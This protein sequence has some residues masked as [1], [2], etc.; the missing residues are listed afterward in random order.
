MVPLAYVKGWMSPRHQSEHHVFRYKHP[1][2][3]SLKCLKALKL[4]MLAGTWLHGGKAQSAALALKAAGASV[5]TIVCIGRWLSYKWDEH[6]PL[7]DSLGEPYDAM[8]CPVTDG[9]YPAG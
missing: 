2:H 7:I 9:A 8:R 6:Q 5:V 4:M 3:P 1:T